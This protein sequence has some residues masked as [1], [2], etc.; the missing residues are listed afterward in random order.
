MQYAKLLILIPVFIVFFQ[1]YHYAVTRSGPE[2]Q[3]TC[4]GLGIAAF[5]IGIVSLVSRDYFFVVV[6]LVSIM[7][8]F[9]LIAHGLDRLD[10]KVF[11]DRYHEPT[12]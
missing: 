7:V 9:R 1:I 2:K 10:K 8:G 11:I 3:R 5:T 6:G 12:E 4:R